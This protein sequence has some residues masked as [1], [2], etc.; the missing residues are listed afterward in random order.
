MNIAEREKQMRRDAID[1]VTISDVETL[2]PGKK[3]GVSGYVNAEVQMVLRSMCNAII[4]RVPVISYDNA[5]CLVEIWCNK[6]GQ[7]PRYHGDWRRL[8]FTVIKDAIFQE[9]VESHGIVVHVFKV[10]TFDK[11]FRFVWISDPDRNFW[12]SPVRYPEDP[13]EARRYGV[14]RGDCANV[15]GILNRSDG[16]VF[17]P[18]VPSQ[19]KDL[20]THQLI[21]GFFFENWKYWLLDYRRKVVRNFVGMKLFDGKLETDNLSTLPLFH[22]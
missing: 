10:T 7:E 22:R 9:Q 19:D 15:R 13:V 18:K 12:Q 8:Q 20:H 14:L 17:G 21:G 2:V 6:K 1:T 5:Q 16:S 11:D 4:Y 3:Y